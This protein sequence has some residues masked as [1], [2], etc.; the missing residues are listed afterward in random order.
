M[1]QLRTTELYYCILIYYSPYRLVSLPVSESCL[2][3]GHLG[4]NVFSFHMRVND[5]YYVCLTNLRNVIMIYLDI[6]K[7]TGVNIST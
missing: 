6:L 2:S 7:C 1:W 4:F 5:Y 3:L